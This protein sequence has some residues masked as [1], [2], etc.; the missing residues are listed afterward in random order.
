[1]P[2]SGKPTSRYRKGG[3]KWPVVLAM[4][5]AEFDKYGAGVN[6]GLSWVGLEEFVK[7]DWDQQLRYHAYVKE[8]YQDFRPDQPFPDLFPKTVNL[9]NG[10]CVRRPKTRRRRSGR[11][12]FGT[13]WVV[14]SGLSRNSN[15]WQKVTSYESSIGL[16]IEVCRAQKNCAEP[17]EYRILCRRSR[18]V[19]C[20]H[21]RIPGGSF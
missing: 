15:P 16:M 21:S 7:L 13:T 3:P 18:E 1:M 9:Y 2:I 20:L 10:Q 11:S 14:R 5:R 8:Q 6:W 17:I 19:R 12:P 4:P